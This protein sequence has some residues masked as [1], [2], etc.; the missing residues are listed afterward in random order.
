MNEQ[1]QNQTLLAKFITGV[2]ILILVACFV[3]PIAMGIQEFV[4]A[5]DIFTAPFVLYS[6]VSGLMVAFVWF[7]FWLVVAVGIKMKINK[8]TGAFGGII[9]CVVWL[10]FFH[11]CEA[12]LTYY[13]VD[14]YIN[15][16][17]KEY[18]SCGYQHKTTNKSQYSKI[19]VFAQADIG[20]APYEALG[21]RKIGGKK[22]RKAI[23]KLN[24]KYEG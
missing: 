12:P 16:E 7:Y 20:C 14:K 15:E 22:G 3:V 24:E 19:F 23:E 5:S 11:F 1:T 2:F 17:A 10:A 21:L 4:Q 9:V 18:V 6:G 13:Y 8:W